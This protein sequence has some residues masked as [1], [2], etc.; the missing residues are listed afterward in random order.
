MIE[1]SDMSIASLVL[2]AGPVVKAVML[3]L[4]FASL[5]SWYVIVTRY[6]VLSRARKAG[7]AFEE[8]SGPAV[9]WPACIT[10]CA[11]NPIR[12]LAPRRF[13]APGSRNS[14]G[15]RRLPGT[16]TR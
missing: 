2:H 14:C 12:T 8:N 1:A 10:R 3:V 16:V 6:R 4:L 15:C 9:I 5:F 11:R 13:S 7:Q